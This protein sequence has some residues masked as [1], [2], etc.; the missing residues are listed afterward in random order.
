MTSSKHLPSLPA[1]KLAQRWA[2]SEATASKT[3]KVTTQ[4]VVRNALYPIERRFRTRQA[5]LHYPQLSG[6]HGRFYT[7]TFFSS[8]K[9]I[10][11]ATCCQLFGNDIGFTQVYPMR[12]KSEAHLSLKSFIHNVGIPH[13]LHSDTDLEGLLT[14]FQ[15]PHPPERIVRTNAA[16]FAFYGFG[17]ASG[18]GFGSTITTPEGIRYRYGIW[19]DDLAGLS[20]NYREL[21]NLTEAAA[22]H[23]SRLRFTHLQNLVTSIEAEATAGCLAPCEF[24]LFTDNAVAEA[25]FYKG[26]SS[27]LLLFDLVLRLKQLELQHSFSLYVLH[28]SGKRMQAQ[29][30]DGLSRGD[31][32]AGVMKGQ[33]LTEFIPLH[34]DAVARS[35]GIVPWCSS[36]ILDTSQLHLLTPTEWF[37]VG[38]GIRS[39][40]PNLDHIWAP[41]F[42]P[43]DQNVFLWAPPPAAAQVAMEQLSFARLKRPSL[44]HIF[45][46]PRLMTH[47]WR[48]QLYKVADVVFTL[49]AGRRPN[50]WSAPM[51][52]PLVLGIIL[53]YLPFAPWSR[54]STEPV[55]DV[56]SQL[57]GVWVSLQGGE[58]FILQKLWLSL[59]G[60]R[61]AVGLGVA[62]VTHL[63]PWIVFMSTSQRMRMDMS[64]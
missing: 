10:D 51:F 56:V 59:G 33:P 44:A 45:I 25:A 22:D 1:A 28:I 27:S 50:V 7:D 49:D 23:I 54:R 9:S 12:V 29:G 4:K 8:V 6:R 41:S 32:F 17:D 46:C 11:V 64:G 57:S 21:F 48:K 19:G 24:Y 63:T 18:S 36:W 62:V 34:L 60:L 3:L 61:F 58:R 53:P 14:L 38:H 47:L 20:S 15:L 43:A 52:E 55:L 13:I 40:T 5:Q 37:S 39:W 35:S 30:T 31:L 2:I 42:Y 16:T 26:T